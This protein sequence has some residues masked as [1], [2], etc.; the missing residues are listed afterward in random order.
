[1]LERAIGGNISESGGVSLPGDKKIDEALQK[2]QT[3]IKK[4]MEFK[5]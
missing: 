4:L 3:K 5:P 1:M 2:V